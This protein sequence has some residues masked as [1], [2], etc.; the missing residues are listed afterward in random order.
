MRIAVGN[1]E[2]LCTCLFEDKQNKGTLG[3][4]EHSVKAS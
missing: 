4:T 3:F 2:P 1:V